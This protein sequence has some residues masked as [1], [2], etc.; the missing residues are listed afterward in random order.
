MIILLSSISSK[1]EKNRTFPDISKIILNFQSWVLY[2]Y[3]YEEDRKIFKI[4]YNIVLL[5][6]IFDYQNCTVL[7]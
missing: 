4:V 1:I 6:K 3:P 7:W 5:N 2:L